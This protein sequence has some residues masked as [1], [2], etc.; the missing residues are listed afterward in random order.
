MVK[1][2]RWLF[3]YVSFR[4]SGGFA[5]G[6]VERCRRERLGVYDLYADTDGLTG[7]I[8][9]RRYRLLRPVARASG[10]RLRLLQKRGAPFVFARFRGRLGLL[11]GVV[12]CI[13]L[14]SYMT[15]FVWTVEVKGCRTISEASV[16]DFLETQGFRV[17][18]KKRDVDNDKIQTAAM[19]A[20][21]D[22]AWIHI[23]IHG[24]NAVV[25]VSESVH[26][27]QLRDKT[28]ANIVAAKDGEITQVI[29]AGGEAAVQP[30]SAVTKGDLLI[31]GVYASEVDEKNHFESAAGSVT[32]K[33][34]ETLTV[35]VQRAAEE[36]RET[37][38]KTVQTLLLF[39]L[40]I[41]LG[42]AEQASGCTVQSDTQLLQL[43]GK[44]LP[45]G[46]RQDTYVY[47]EKNTY[48]RTDEELLQLARSEMQEKRAEYA[49]NA[50][51]LSE[52]ETADTTDAACTLK[53]SLTAVEEIGV[54]QALQIDVSADDSS[55]E[56]DGRT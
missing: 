38:R 20:F 2:L 7:K 49:E 29:C 17:G 3:G 31:S 12:A 54:R 36:K 6:F 5:Q 40:E 48:L 18:V 37:Q 10:G 41:P 23:N 24:T 25:E 32:A 21:D 15:S 16:L 42:F 34:H 47:Y 8:A 13:L 28:P 50:V 4:F 9:A 1:L 52:K 11:A 53:L 35:T 46:L 26:A 55:S 14:F 27:P 19:A 33:V 51:I 22:A 44:T 43:G 39:G 45:L 56:S 30:G